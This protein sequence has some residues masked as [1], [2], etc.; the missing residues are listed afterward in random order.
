[1]RMRSWYH[2]KSIA[3]CL[4]AL[5]LCCARV[6]KQYIFMFCH[7]LVPKPG[8]R[9]ILPV[10]LHLNDPYTH[11]HI[12]QNRL[13]NYSIINGNVSISWDISK[14][15]PSE[16]YSCTSSHWFFPSS[17]KV[18]VVTMQ[19]VIR[20][21]GGELGATLA[22]LPTLLLLSYAIISILYFPRQLSN[23]ISG[24]GSLLLLL[25]QRMKSWTGFTSTMFCDIH[26]R[27]H[28]HTFQV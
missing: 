13:A 23:W 25:V 20:R 19:F 28:V 14:I 17:W 15:V 12:L 22:N 26:Y 7:I 27:D 3:A 24:W 8:T 9:L 16:V 6:W 2:G 18:N 5:L 11:T 21:G 4:V 10:Q 1:M